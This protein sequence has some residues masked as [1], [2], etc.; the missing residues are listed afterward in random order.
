MTGTAITNYLSTR[1]DTKESEGVITFNA[2]ATFRESIALNMI[3]Q[4][5]DSA[6]RQA[7]PMLQCRFKAYSAMAELAKAGYPF[8][9]LRCVSKS[10]QY[11][12]SLG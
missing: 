12:P 4:A 1:L 8:M 5:V 6:K 2:D 3:S 11:C 10:I 7:L 9:R